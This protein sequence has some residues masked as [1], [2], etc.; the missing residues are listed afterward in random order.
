MELW[1]GVRVTR[2]N[3]V[4]CITKT[5]C[6]CRKHIDG[7]VYVKLY[8]N[9]YY[10]VHSS[11][12]IDSYSAVCFTPT[13]DKISDLTYYIN[14]TCKLNNDNLRS[15]DRRLWSEVATVLSKHTQFVGFTNVRRAF[16]KV[17]RDEPMF[18][19]I[20]NKII[21]FKNLEKQ[22]ETLRIRDIALTVFVLRDKIL[23]N[24]VIKKII[25]MIY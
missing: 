1:E 5:C 24:D 10:W 9:R 16:L 6:C 18:L 22:I 23:S 25:G 19:Q 3:N 13:F 4:N 14:E 17:P 15:I 2:S 20:K 21:A 11:C 12:V 8:N 7:P